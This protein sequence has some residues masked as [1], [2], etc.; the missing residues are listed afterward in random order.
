MSDGSSMSGPGLFNYMDIGQ[1]SQALG[2]IY[3]NYNSYMNEYKQAAVNFLNNQNNT[4]WQKQAA[5][6]T[7]PSK[8][9]QAQYGVTGSPAPTGASGW[10]RGSVQSS[11]GFQDTRR[12]G[13][14]QREFQGV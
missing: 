13:W 6:D 3:N 14:G 11:E 8:R 12:R 2:D 4:A 7:D 5:T 9:E 1:Q 10:G